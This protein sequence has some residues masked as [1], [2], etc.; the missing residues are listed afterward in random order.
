MGRGGEGGGKQA[1]KVNLTK[2]EGSEGGRGFLFV[3]FHSVL[4]I[5]GVR[6]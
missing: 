6:G 3:S 1:V 5:L 4:R 2:E